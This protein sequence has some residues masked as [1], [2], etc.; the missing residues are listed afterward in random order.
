MTA[1]GRPSWRGEAGGWHRS[2]FETS[3]RRASVGDLVPL[4]EPKSGRDIDMSGSPQI[5][6]LK[7]LTGLTCYTVYSYKM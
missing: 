1:A 5:G 4:I 2:A 3:A 6:S 7:T